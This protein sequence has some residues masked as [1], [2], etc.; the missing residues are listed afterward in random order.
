MN[1]EGGAGAPMPS[2]QG[3][4]S[5]SPTRSTRRGSGPTRLDHDGPDYW[6]PEGEEPALSRSANS[7]PPRF[8]VVGNPGHRRVGLFQDAVRAAGLSP[9]RVVTWL[10]VLNGA[11]VF[12]PGETV[13]I[14][15]PGEDAEVER[16]LRGVE[17]P[18]RVEGSSRWYARFT[19]AVREV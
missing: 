16:L 6:D 8:A 9:A 13:R 7:A 19:S 5:T 12:L 10:D 11:A 2:A 17:D 15:S 18:T 3:S 14:D 4:V 1:S